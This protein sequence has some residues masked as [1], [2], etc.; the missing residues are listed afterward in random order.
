MADGTTTTKTQSARR[1]HRGLD[2]S[3]THAKQRGTKD[4][5]PLALHLPEDKQHG[6]NCRHDT[7]SRSFLGGGLL[8]WGLIAII[9]LQHRSRWHCRSLRL[10]CRRALCRYH[11][12]EGRLLAGG[13][14]RGGNIHH[15]G[16]VAW[17][18]IC[19]LDGAVVFGHPRRI[20]VF[21]HLRADE[22]NSFGFVLEDQLDIGSLAA[23]ALDRDGEVGFAMGRHLNWRYLNHLE[24]EGSSGLARQ[25]QEKE[26][27]KNR[28]V[29]FHEH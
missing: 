8:G 23:Q 27:E 21:D 15:K 29:I 1:T 19:C 16:V 2:Y 11:I 18:H 24:P 3:L 25:E 22:I 9:C 7:R 14:S 10:N 4:Q 26:N 6:K 12:N 5:S 17:R 28:E 13:R 20:D